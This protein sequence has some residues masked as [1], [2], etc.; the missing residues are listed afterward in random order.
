LDLYEHYLKNFNFPT[1]EKLLNEYIPVA[2]LFYTEFSSGDYLQIYDF[3]K[4]QYEVFDILTKKLGVNLYKFASMYSKNLHK[5]KDNYKNLVGG[6][7]NSKF[8]K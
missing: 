3:L 1:Y 2:E 8:M 6:I 5:L 4:E 7:D